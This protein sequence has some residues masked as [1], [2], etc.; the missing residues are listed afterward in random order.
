MMQVEADR[1]KSRHE[2]RVIDAGTKE[3]AS[4][5]VCIYGSS[6]SLFKE[7]IFF[8]KSKIVSLNRMCMAI[9]VFAHQKAGDLLQMG[10]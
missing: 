5:T 3:C 1:M 6:E 7:P 4:I 9:Q 2:L 10:F 8:F